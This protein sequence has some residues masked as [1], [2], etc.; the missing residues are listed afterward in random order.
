MRLLIL[1]EL[2]IA[3]MYVRQ[4]SI[5]AKIRTSTTFRQNRKTY[6]KETSPEKYDKNVY[7]LM[8]HKDCYYGLYNL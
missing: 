7:I 6:S 4:Q 1:R 8:L 3:H 2:I 5:R